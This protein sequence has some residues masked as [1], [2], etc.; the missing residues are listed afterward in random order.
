MWYEALWLDGPSLVASLSQS[1]SYIS[2][3]HSYDTLKFV[4]HGLKDSLIL[5]VK[6]YFFY[7]IYSCRNLLSLHKEWN[8]TLFVESILFSDIDYCKWTH[9]TKYANIGIVTILLSQVVLSL[10]FIRRYSL[11]PFNLKSWGHQTH[12]KVMSQQY[13]SSLLYSWGVG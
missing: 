11:L 13:T 8:I 2:S 1:V 6:K 7:L 9:V 12:H 10:W 3:Y 4:W 5:L